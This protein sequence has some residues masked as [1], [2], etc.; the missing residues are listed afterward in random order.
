MVLSA[1][2]EV[3][4]TVETAS[5]AKAG[6]ATPA[7]VLRETSSALLRELRRFVLAAVIVNVASVGEYM[8][9][10]VYTMYYYQ[11]M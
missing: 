1:P 3:H 9:F 7:N 4:A 10:I 11:L 5:A 6:R 2:A 8:L